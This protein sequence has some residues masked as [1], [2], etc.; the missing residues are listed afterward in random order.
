MAIFISR[1]PGMDD[2]QEIDGPGRAREFVWISLFQEHKL[3]NG[4]GYPGYD[5]RQEKESWINHAME[6][7]LGREEKSTKTRDGAETRYRILI[8]MLEVDPG[9]VIIIP[10]VNDVR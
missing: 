2:W 3:H 7:P 6:H 1:L 8:P 10:G 4:W 9:D 5:L